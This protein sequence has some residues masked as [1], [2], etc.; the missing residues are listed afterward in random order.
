MSRKD[1]KRISMGDDDLRY[2]LPDAKILTYSE[3]SNYKK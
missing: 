3:L 2:Y 1:V